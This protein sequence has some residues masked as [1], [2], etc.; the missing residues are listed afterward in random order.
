MIIVQNHVKDGAKTFLA[1]EYTY[2]AIFCAMFAVILVCLVD[3]PWKNNEAGDKIS[4]PMTTLAFLIGAA[5]SML[6]GYIG[7]M[8]ATDANAKTTAETA[9]SINDGFKVAFRGG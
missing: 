1:K 3:Q 8:V 7:M 6:C 2:L 5:T 4:F 9:K